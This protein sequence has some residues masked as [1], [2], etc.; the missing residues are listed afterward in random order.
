M[1]PTL[2]VASRRGSRVRR[3]K[4]QGAH[5]MANAAEIAYQLNL[6]ETGKG[7]YTGFCPSC[8][9]GTGFSVI[10][11]NGRTL[12][13]CH[14]GGCTQQQLIQALGERG[15]WGDQD[16]KSVDFPLEHPG[17]S[18][19]ADSAEAARKMWERSQPA[20]GTVVET[21][22]RVRGYF[23]SIPMSIRYVRGKHPAD[24]NFHPAMLAAALILGDPPEFGGIHR[25]FLQE[26]G[27][28]KASLS[29]NKMSLGNIG[30]AG[31]LLSV[32]GSKVAVAEGIETGLSVQQAT[33]IP[34][35][36]ALSAGGVQALLLPARLREV[37]IAADPDDVGMQAAQSAAR[38][39]H[40]EGRIVRI[41]TPPEG[42]DFNDLAR[43]AR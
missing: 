29:P 9:Y 18:R 8:C 2:D 25:T 19:K 6:T 38:R 1:P 14:A 11:K 39:W 12:F 16:P 36:A 28:G 4:T 40:G 30:G 27:S 15:L 22:L 43:G 10:D 37:F 5:N 26:D 24:E 34:T 31:V 35:I 41:V 3:Y 20:A 23:G 7:G 13:H 17:P 32:P 42:S 21:Y 33:G